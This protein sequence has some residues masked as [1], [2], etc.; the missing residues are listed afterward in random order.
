MASAALA[1]DD[2]ALPSNVVVHATPQET[3]A[4]WA[5]KM[6]RLILD[7]RNV[8]WEIADTLEAGRAQFGDDPQM[9]LFLDAIGYDQKRAIADAKV[10]KLIPAAWRTDK[11]SFEV[12]KHIA[13]VE[14]PELRRR[15][16]KQAEAEHWN[17]RAAH[18]AVVEHKVA[19]GTLFGDDDPVARLS[20]EIVRC[21]N[22]ATPDA[23]EYFYQLAEMSAASGFGIIDQDLAI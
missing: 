3:I 22:R 11:I 14:D 5:D 15:M 2:T 23:R 7:K 16:I 1:I 8:E 10:A 9:Q 18:H 19:S 6:R 21:W 13:K 17:E 4:D 20:T 12:C